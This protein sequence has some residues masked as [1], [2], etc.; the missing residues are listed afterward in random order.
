MCPLLRAVA[1]LALCWALSPSS[2]MAQDL[3][4]PRETLT[5]PRQD[6]PAPLAGPGTVTL[7]DVA[8]LRLPATWGWLP[9]DEGR[10]YLRTRDWTS[11][12][13]L[14]VAVAMGEP[15][16]FAVFSREGSGHIDDAEAVDFEL[17]LRRLQKRADDEIAFRDWSGDIGGT[18]IL[19][20]AEPPR[21]DRRAHH[22]VWS[23]RLDG[24]FYGAGRMYIVGRAP[25]LHAN[26]FVC[27]RAG[28]IAITCVGDE[29]QW[30]R[31]RGQLQE[32]L[33]ATTFLPGHRY[34]DFDAASDP[35]DPRGLGYLVA[36]DLSGPDRWTE[37][38]WRHRGWVSLAAGLLAAA[39]IWLYSRRALATH[40]DVP[41]A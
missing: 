11:Y 35:V 39:A 37:L 2:A 10:R 29:A 20:W 26:G 25:G 9:P 34:E 28:A 19:G 18:A 41:A 8:E 24:S 1:A 13:V 14:G 17:L 4:I 5:I 12:D 3:R 30:P 36:R 38:V 7:A 22:L 23:L 27:G 6:P 33:H 21:Y 31:I 32:L 40:R 16:S 15:D